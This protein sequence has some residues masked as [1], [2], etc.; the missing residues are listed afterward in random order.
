[1]G[2]KNNYYLFDLQTIMGCEQSSSTDTQKSSGPM[3]YTKLQYF[4]LHGR[5]AH[6]RMTLWYCGIKYED[7]RLTQEEFGKKKTAGE[8]Q[9]G[10]LP[11][12]K[13][14]TGLTLTQT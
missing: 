9:W 14:S 1:M 4:D 6:L 3:G 2:N 5:A 7:C 12:L 11:D 10:S 8:F 13:L